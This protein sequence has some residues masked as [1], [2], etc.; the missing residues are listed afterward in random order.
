MSLPERERLI[1]AFDR[2]LAARPEIVLACLH[3]SYFDFLPFAWQ[4]LREVR[5]E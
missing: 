2:E 5:S 3:G 4:Y 1:S